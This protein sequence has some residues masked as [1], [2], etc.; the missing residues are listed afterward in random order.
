M[1]RGYFTQSAMVLFEKAPSID[2]VARAIAEL[3]PRQREMDAKS[4]QW[5]SSATDLLVGFRP[6]AHG[7]LAIDVV[8]APWPDEM[9]DPE[10]DADLFGAWTMGSFG[11]LVF[12]GNLE[13]AAQQAVAFEGAEA[14]TQKHGG[15]VRL[16]TTYVIGAGE[17]AKVVPDNWDPMEELMAI[18]GASRALLELPGA[19]AY[20]DPN[21]E[22]ILPREALDSA[23]AHSMALKLPPIDL[24]SHVRLFQIDEQWSLMDTVG[25]ERFFLPDIE[26]AIDQRI[27]PNQAAEFLRNVS[28]FL[29]AK[30]PVVKAG[31]TMD[32]PGGRY[33]ASEREESLVEPPRKVVRLVPEGATLPADLTD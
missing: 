10:S 22:V 29:L 8:D 31:H 20:F 3:E 24:F 33:V 9:G 5:M 12:P 18:L 14:L 11:P 25:L 23:I 27:D 32:G 1:P 15:F 19:L 7:E 30:G 17:D 21:A 6:E 13:R 4:T 2:D 26:I 16:R 28:L